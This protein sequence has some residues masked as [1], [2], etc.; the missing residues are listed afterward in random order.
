MY[1]VSRQQR[2]GSGIAAAIVTA[3]IGWAL[4]L[5]LAGGAVKA[6]VDEG[7]ALFRLTPTSPKP[8]PRVIPARRVSQRASGRAS[9]RNIRSQAT[10][11]AAPV[12]IVTVPVPPP[13]VT[14]TVKPFAGNQATQGAAPVAG[15]GTGAGGVGDGTGAGGSGDGDGGG[16]GDETPPRWLRG[17]LRDSDYPRGIGEQGVQGLVSVR[18]LVGTAGRV[19]DCTITRSSG[20]GVLDATTCRLIE[21]RFRYAPSRDAQGRPVPAWILENHEWVVEDVPGEE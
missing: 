6:K 1:A 10:Q 15:P 9:P 8:K 21:Q 18:F 4:L 14:V 5:G 20:S 13:R 11:I 2:L 12:P 16:Y 17:R 19:T 3:V 7:L